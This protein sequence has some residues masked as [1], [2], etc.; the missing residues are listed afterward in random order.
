MQATTATCRAGAAFIPACPKEAAY[1]AFASTIR[2]VTVPPAA[3]ALSE[4]VGTDAE[5]V[6]GMT[7]LVTPGPG[8]LWKWT[9]NAAERWL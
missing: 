5:V 2:S 6:I 8:L 3:M 7:L 1:R 4:P 9:K